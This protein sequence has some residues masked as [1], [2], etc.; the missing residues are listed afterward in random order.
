[1]KSTLILLMILLLCCILNG[2]TVALAPTRPLEDSPTPSA[3]E[4]LFPPFCL[5]PSSSTRPPT[6]SPDCQYF[7]G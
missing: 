2:C 1:M 3:A 6:Q 4:M 7:P 5:S